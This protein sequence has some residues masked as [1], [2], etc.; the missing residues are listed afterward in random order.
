MAHQ[1]PLLAR[2]L[3]HQHEEGMALATS[4]DLLVLTP[5]GP[6][7]PV[8]TYFAHF[9]CKGLVR[10]NGQVT[11][12]DDHLVGIQF[13]DDYLKHFDTAR[14]LTWCQPADIWHPNIRPPFICAG[15]MQP[16]TPVVDLL[17][18]VFEIITWQNVETREFNA[19]NHDACV[20]ARHNVHRFPVDQRPL[21]RRVRTPGDETRYSLAATGPKEN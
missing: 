12:H 15:R 9:C 16:G 7:S 2:F 14:V 20:W 5:V 17:Y 10:R 18:Q 1:D 4:S 19:L 21:K 11:E 8:T 6:G 13:P 3:E